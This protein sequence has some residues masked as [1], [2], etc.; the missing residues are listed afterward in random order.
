MVRCNGMNHL[1]RLPVFFCQISANARVG[2]FDL[3][4]DCF[5]Y[6]MKQ[7]GSFGLFNINAQFRSHHSAQKSHLKGML[8]DVLA[9]AGPV[10]QYAEKTNKLH[11]NTMCSNIKG[12]LFTHLPNG[13]LKFFADLFNYLFNPCR[14]N[15][16]VHDQTFQGKARHFPPDRIESGEYH[17][18]GRVINYYIDSGSRLNCTNISALSADY[19]ALH[20]IIR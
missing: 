8:K 6:V 20:F 16:T 1:G 17:G 15:P 7:T 12:R 4:V 11:V 9:V 5:A 19:P 3:V 18:F 13:H 2:P 10:F 14:M